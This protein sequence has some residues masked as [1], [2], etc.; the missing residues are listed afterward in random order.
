MLHVPFVCIKI[1]CVCK[2]W[3][4][5]GNTTEWNGMKAKIKLHFDISNYNDN[6]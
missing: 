1:V 3:C 4:E 5:H 2:K 6:K